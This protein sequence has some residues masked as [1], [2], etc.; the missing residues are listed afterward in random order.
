MNKYLAISKT[1]IEQEMAYRIN[2]VMSRVR[3]LFGIILLYYLWSSVFASGTTQVFGYDREKILTYVFMV[4]IIKSFVFTSKAGDIAGEIAQ[5]ELNKYLVKPINFTYYYL[6]KDAGAKLLNTLFS[7]FEFALLFLLFKPPIVIQ[8][9]ISTLFFFIISLLLAVLIYFNIVRLTS[10]ITFSL[11]EYAW[12]AHFLISGVITTFLSG[13]VFPIDILPLALQKAIYLT[14]FPYL[15]FFP[16]EIYLG[17]LT[18]DFIIFGVAMSFFWLLI[19]FFISQ[20]V[21]RSGL[22]VYGAYGG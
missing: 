22:K 10:F 21:W 7:V 11:P 5:G 1:T 16:L 2:F 18:M 13:A 4:L 14:P 15:L 9:D 12:G 3:N 6:A 20:R 8:G 19:L 17:R